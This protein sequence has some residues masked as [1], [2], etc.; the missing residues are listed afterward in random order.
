MVD[1]PNSTNQSLKN[2]KASF[3]LKATHLE[4]NLD[5]FD[6]DFSS[7]DYGIHSG[8]VGTGFFVS[9]D[10]EITG[11]YIEYGVG[12]GV[13]VGDISIPCSGDRLIKY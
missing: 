8:F 13:T 2:L 9:M 4:G 11:Q 10:G 7:M 6:E 1:N 12:V 5:D 3:V